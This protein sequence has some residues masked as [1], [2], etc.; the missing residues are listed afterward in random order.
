[1]HAIH[2]QW[3]TPDQTRTVQLA[4]HQTVERSGYRIIAFRDRLM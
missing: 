2:Q 4:P 3:R 1:L